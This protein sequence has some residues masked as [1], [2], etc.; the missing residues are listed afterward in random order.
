MAPKL[1]AEQMSQIS[2][3]GKE[4]RSRKVKTGVVQERVQAPALCNY[5]L[6]EF[7]TLPLN[8]KLNKYADDI[9][10]YTSGPFVADLI[11][12]LNIYQSHVLNYI[13][14]KKLTVSKAKSKVSHFTPDIRA[15]HLHSQV[16]MADRVLPP[17]KKPSVLRVRL[18]T[19]LMFTQ[20]CNNFAVRVQLR[21]NVL[22]ELSGST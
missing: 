8:T 11:N 2:F 4:S 7:P 21:N 22:N 18:D 3:L 20:H 1:Y 15:H 12:G 13:D 5:Y 9:T 14:I 16:K 10:I 17:D 19:H 6:A